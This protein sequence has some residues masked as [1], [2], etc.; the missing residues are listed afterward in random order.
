M[1]RLKLWFTPRKEKRIHKTWFQIVESVMNMANEVQQHGKPM[2]TKIAAI[3]M[4]KDKEIGDFDIVSI[5]CGVGE[6]NP[7][8]RSKHLKAQN[9]HMKEL[10]IS[11]RSKLSIG[12]DDDLI[13]NISIVLDTFE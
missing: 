8:E 6:A 1:K 7:I 3:D 5:W 12:Q 13:V 11:C 9:S 10:L 4:S 2:L